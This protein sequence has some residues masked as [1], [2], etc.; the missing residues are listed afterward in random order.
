MSRR[1]SPP[2]PDAVLLPAGV[3]IPQAGSADTPFGLQ[4]VCHTLRDAN[5]T[6][7]RFAW[8]GDHLAVAEWTRLTE[9]AET[10]Y[11]Q[12]GH[13]TL[14]CYLDGGYRTERQKLPGRFGAPSRLCALPGD[15]ESRWWV[16]GHMH[17]IHLYFLP[18]HFTQRAVQELDREPREMTLADRTYFEDARIASLCQSLVFEQWDDPDGRLRTNETAHEVLSLLLRSQG[19]RR[20]G[21]ALKGGLSVAIRRRLRDYIDSHL[22]Q[23]ITLG[24]LAGVAGLSEFHFA[25]MFRTSFGLPPHAWVAQQRLERARTLLRTTALPLV[26]VAAA[27]GY[28][29]ASHF[30]HRFREAFGVAPVVFRQAVRAA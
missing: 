30:S 9:E 14:S 22:T 17:F 1:S 18:E 27:C 21:A 15:H 20:A 23:S 12:P 5:A 24:E 16:R 4:S 3:P 7:E 25:R 29:N 8:L 6:L 19:V 11:E 10:V 13:H 28:A 2:A 26:Q